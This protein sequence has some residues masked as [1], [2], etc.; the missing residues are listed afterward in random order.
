MFERW[1]RIGVVTAVVTLSA[2]VAAGCSKKESEKLAENAAQKTAENATGGGVDLG[3]DVKVGTEGGTGAV[4]ESTEWPAGEFP[5]LPKFTYATVERT[6]YTV[7]KEGQKGVTVALRDLQEGGIEKYVKDLENAGWEIQNN[8]KTGTG[9]LVQAQKGKGMGVTVT[10]KDAD[11][12]V[13]L[14]AYAGMDQ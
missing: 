2:L 1:K 14:S 11:R 7:T 8:L 4:S 9:G 13:A 10:Y 3:G 6:A 5:D 12:S